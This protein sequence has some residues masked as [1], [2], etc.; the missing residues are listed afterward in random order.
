M[1]PRT[2]S[3]ASPGERLEAAVTAARIRAADRKMRQSELIAALGSPA[4]R[5]TAGLPASGDLPPP[6]QS[7]R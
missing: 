4:Q 6:R 3:R 7:S 5:A 1:A 2:I